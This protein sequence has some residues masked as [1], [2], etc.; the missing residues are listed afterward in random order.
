MEDMEVKP[1]VETSGREIGRHLPQ[2][3]AEL[4][5]TLKALQRP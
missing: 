2:I 1:P 5:T 4:H 3:R